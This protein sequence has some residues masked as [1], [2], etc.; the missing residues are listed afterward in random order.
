[1]DKKAVLTQDERYQ[2]EKANLAKTY[3][4]P[5]NENL[6]R[7]NDEGWYAQIKRHYLIDNFDS[8]QR[9]D[10]NYYS[11]A[12][13]NGEAHRA[14]W[15]DNRQAMGSKIAPLINC[16]IR[17]VLST[18]GLHEYHPL[19]IK[20]GNAVR[21]NIEDLKLF[22]CDFRDQKKPEPSNMFILRRLVGLI[23]YKLP[24]VG[25]L[26]VEVN[27]VKKRVRVHGVAAPDF[28]KIVYTDKKGNQQEKLAL[29]ANGAAIPISD[30]REEVFLAWKIK[31]ELEI[32]HEQEIQRKQE[33]A[34]QISREMQQ[35]INN[36]NYQVIAATVEAVEKM[37]DSPE[38]IVIKQ[39]VKR[40]VENNKQ[41]IRNL[42]ATQ[43]KWYEG[44]KQVI[45]P[46]EVQP[47]KS[48]KILKRNIHQENE[49]FNLKFQ[50]VCEL[51]TLKLFEKAKN[52]VE[53]YGMKLREHCKMWVKNLDDVLL[54][55]AA[56]E[57]LLSC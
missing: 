24:Q 23:G 45:D 49:E 20:V 8:L 53:E 13:K 1:L 42:Q 22:I 21:N 3:Q 7:K 14:I 26:T 18:S 19:A 41:E 12:L 35:E 28:A 51:I 31:E 33:I 37:S 11:H 36:S 25:Q 57:M 9:Q 2:L 54:K 34:D 46:W 4:V 10:K 27:S 50:E 16:G 44:Q 55:N 47:V 32:A 40:V 29:D 38:T 48:E 52:V 30:G 56:L 5:V 6:A 43:C 39:A 17:D 15:D